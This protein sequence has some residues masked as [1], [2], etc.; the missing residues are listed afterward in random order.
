VP[1]YGESSFLMYR[2]DLMQK[3]GI[4]MPTRP[5]WDQVEQI[6]ARMHNAKTGGS[7]S[8]CGATPAGARTWRR[9]TR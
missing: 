9:S 5:T 1:F 6:A 3:A 8:A 2:K 7:A 4:T